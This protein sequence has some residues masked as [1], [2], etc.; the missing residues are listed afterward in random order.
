M[1]LLVS[2]AKP[3]LTLPAAGYFAVQKTREILYRR[4][5]FIAVPAPIPV[6]SV[7]NVLMGGSG[8]TPFVI[9]LAGL[10]HARGFK[11]AVVSRGYRGSNRAPYLV[12][13]DGI[14]GK[15]LAPPHVA[16]DEPFLIAERLP[17]VPVLVGRRRI[18]PVTAAHQLFGVDAVILD[19]GFQRLSL[20]R[21]L[22]M[23][24]VN[25]SE[26][27][28]FPLGRLREPISALS[29][30]DAVIM[31]GNAASLPH[32]ISRFLEGKPLFRV[33]AVAIGL[34]GLPGMNAPEDLAG[35]EVILVSGI[36]NPERFGD[37]AQESGWKVVRHLRFPDHHTY[38]EAELNLILAQAGN[39][40]VVFTEKDWVKLPSS[41]KQTGK[42]GALR[43]GTVAE[44]EEDLLKMASRAIK[45]TRL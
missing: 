17:L 19:D 31:T 5:I 38:R 7:G 10:L 37:L 43:I 41:I 4:G 33:T 42:V 28:M 18:H 22:D 11:V 32:K 21:N 40:P 1:S 39:L 13:G 35:R 26:D 15:P 20:R 3:F 30:A 29:R 9:Y 44:K 16:G 14:S 36:A 25:G 23:V 12:V 2:L 34:V 8:K 45:E 6:L 24:I 27:A